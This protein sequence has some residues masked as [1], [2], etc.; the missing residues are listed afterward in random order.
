M[1]PLTI[2]TAWKEAA[3]PIYAPLRGVCACNDELVGEGET[4]VV[5]AIDQCI[6]RAGPY[7]LTS[8]RI[9][10]N[11]PAIVKASKVAYSQKYTALCTWLNDKAAVELAFSVQPVR[12]A[13]YFFRETGTGIDGDNWVGRLT[14][15]AGIEQI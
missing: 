2:E 7:W 4:I 9:E 11:A 15:T 8:T 3:A 13:G 6:H 14:I 1:N 10:I 5:F 12:L